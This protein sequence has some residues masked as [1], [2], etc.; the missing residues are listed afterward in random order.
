M[1][2][3]YLAAPH[4]CP[5][6]AVAGSHMPA[7]LANAGPDDGASQNDVVK[8]II[9]SMLA[10]LTTDDLN[11][12]RSFWETQQGLPPELDRPMLARCREGLGRDLLSNE[13][14]F[15]RAEFVKA[16]RALPTY[17]MGAV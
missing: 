12:L 7:H 14:R 8:G 5:L 2:P 6:S 11:D 15:A 13:K 16:V 9:D 4:R 10:R 17:L 3:F 1:A